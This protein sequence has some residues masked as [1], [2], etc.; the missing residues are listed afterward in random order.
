MFGIFSSGGGL[1]PSPSQDLAKALSQPQRQAPHQNAPVA[2]LGAGS[3]LSSLQALR[4][5]SQGPW[6][7]SAPMSGGTVTTGQ[8]IDQAAGSMFCCS[9][10]ADTYRVG[11][12]FWRVCCDMQWSGSDEPSAG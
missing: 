9:H 7:P 6:N 8:L 4:E 3:S 10:Q 11:M 12:A 1:S 5:A 2:F